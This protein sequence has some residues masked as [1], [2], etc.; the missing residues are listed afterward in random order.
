MN[1]C[2]I[3]G[4]TG[5]S[6]AGKSTVLSCFESRGVCV[7]NSDLAVK[8]I[9]ESGSVCLKAVAAEFGEDIINP[10]KSLNRALL[11]QRAFA[12]REN[13]ERLNSIVHPF[14]TTELLK[15]L[16]EQKPDVL[17]CDAP[18]LFESG[19]YVLC[20]YIISV[21]ADESIRL[22]RICARDGISREQ[23]MLRI[24]AQ[25]SESFFR[26]NSDFVIENNSDE[27]SLLDRAKGIF[28]KLV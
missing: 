15:L 17:I 6:G 8:R 12:S 4:L 19:I 14:V 9:Y 3:I 2:R 5:Q 23:A 20:D 13:T 11:A 28:D 21:V 18:Q 10:D 16:K 7:F 26:E 22:E 1:R 25:L 24:N 27:K